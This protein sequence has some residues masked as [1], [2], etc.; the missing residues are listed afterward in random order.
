MNSDTAA[1]VRDSINGCP[2]V[3]REDEDRREGDGEPFQT[4]RGRTLTGDS[5]DCD[6]A[7]YRPA[8]IEQSG[9]VGDGEGAKRP[10]Y[11]VVLEP[12]FTDLTDVRLLSAALVYEIAKHDCQIRFYP[13]EH[14]LGGG[15]WIT[16]HVSQDLSN[17]DG[18]HCPDCGGTYFKLRDG[19][20]EC[21]RCGATEE[22]IQR[23]AQ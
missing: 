3:V 14:R 8:Y 6:R 18:D 21:A 2:D 7:S 16:D 10:V 12:L 22:T 5:V 13:P 9:T 17:T 23:K 15:I 20:P 1:A 19:T 4:H 11:V